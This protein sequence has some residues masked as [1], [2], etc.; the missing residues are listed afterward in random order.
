MHWT[1]NKES[2]YHIRGVECHDL[3]YTHVLHGLTLSGKLRMRLVEPTDV[4]LV[5]EI[6]EFHAG[7][8]RP[9]IETSTALIAVACSAERAVAAAGVRQTIGF[10]H[11]AAP[12]QGGTQGV[13]T[14]KGQLLR[15]LLWRMQ[16]G[17]IVCGEHDD[18]MAND[19]LGKTCA[20]RGVTALLKAARNET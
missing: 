8:F 4:Q 14:V 11:P 10:Y 15:A 13:H 16:I 18:C 12:N 5:T 6:S 3:R 17:L 2:A 1:V 9:K 20:R 7:T 19:E